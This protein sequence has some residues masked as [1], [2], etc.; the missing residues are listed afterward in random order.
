VRILI[1]SFDFGPVSSEGIC[2][3]RLVEAFLAEGIWV[4][5]VTS[6]TAKIRFHHDRFHPVTL[7]TWP[8]RPHT[9]FTFLIGLLGGIRL[10]GAHYA[11][12]H[13]VSNFKF[14]D[15]PDLIYGRALPFSSAV[16]AHA[17]AMRLGVPLVTH[18]S[19][20]LPCP[21]DEEDSQG[22]QLMMGGVKKVIAGSLAV[23]FTTQQAMDYQER[24]LNANLSDVGFVLNHIAPKPTYL[25]IRKGGPG[26]TFGYFGGFY[27]KRTASVL[28]EGFA[29]HLHSHPHSRLLCVGTD[30]DVVVPDINR[31]GIGDSV[32]VHGRVSDVRPLMDDI[33]VLLSVD[34]TAGPAIFLPTKLVESLVVNRPVLLLSPATSPG[35]SLARRFQRTVVHASK[36]SPQAVAEGLRLAKNIEATEAE[37]RDRFLGM[38]EFGAQVVARRFLAEMENRNIG[39]P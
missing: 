16:S 21:W 22:F 17:L 20:P 30:P 8:H 9:L 2:T 36:T 39:K 11:W 10:S 18:F 6:S 37:Y 34:A 29:L 7:P 24:M 4:T 12:V 33:D 25:P 38:E 23:T 19:D 14:Q 35:A 28:L 1:C 27:G 26:R 31:L 13:R 3:E 15:R 32:R 5:L